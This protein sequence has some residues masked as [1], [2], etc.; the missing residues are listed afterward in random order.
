M[1]IE[2]QTLH[3]NELPTGPQQVNNWPMGMSGLS[4][5]FVF[6]CETYHWLN[7]HLDL[8]WDRQL[9]LKTH[10]SSFLYT[11]NKKTKNSY[12]KANTNPHL[13]WASLVKI[14]DLK[15]NCSLH[16]NSSL[17]LHFLWRLRSFFK[18]KKCFFEHHIFLNLENVQRWKEI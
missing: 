9:L 14:L 8:H 4:V 17:K 10:C 6:C 13:T 11:Q 7:R 3:Q 2:A 15:N 12:W 16:K 18:T 1:R 5:Y